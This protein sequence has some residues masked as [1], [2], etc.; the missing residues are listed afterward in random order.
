LIAAAGVT[1]AVVRWLSD[2]AARRDEEEAAQAPLFSAE[3]AQLEGVDLAQV[4]MVR[5]PEY[6]ASQGGH[7]ASSG[8]SPED[9]VR[10]ELQG[11]ARLLAI[12]NELVRTRRDMPLAEALIR[13]DQ[14]VLE[15]NE[16]LASHGKPWALY[17]PL[18][19]STRAYGLWAYSYLRLGTVEVT[20]LAT[21]V[22]IDLVTRMDDLAITES[23]EGHA[24]EESA[25][26]VVLV[27]QVADNAANTLWPMLA[28]G[29][30]TDQGHP[31]NPLAQSVRAELLTALPQEAREVLVETAAAR[32]QLVA[33][34]AEINSASRCEG[35][36]ILELPARGFS[37]E[38]PTSG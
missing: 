10:A 36:T 6:F 5:L 27:D 25:T 17:L 2:A 34:V 24:R 29:Q 38:N 15:W 12:F 20:N 8:L 37:S 19:P 21:P 30:Q 35:F 32:A 18:S 16:H 33:T 23:Y 26:V 31:A 22:T 11:S 7:G 1:Y 4:H 14:L 9:W 13:E 28:E 3:E